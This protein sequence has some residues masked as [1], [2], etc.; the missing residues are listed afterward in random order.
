MK[1]CLVSTH[2]DEVREILPLGLAY[3]A[4]YM[5]DKH[6]FDNTSII[7]VNIE[8]PM[9]G[10]RREKPDV[11]GISTMTLN[12]GAS[13]RLA[14]E[15]KEELDV[16]MLIGGGHISTLHESL[17]KEFDVGVVGEGEETLA[18][19]VDLFE[20][21]GSFP[22]E[23][24]E[25]IEGLVYRKDGALK[26]SKHRELIR[27]LD[28]IPI[29]D[30]KFLSKEYFKPRVVF[31]DGGEVGVE[32]SIFTSRGCPYDCVFCSSAMFWNK[33]RF[34][35]AQRFIDEVR[36][37]NEEY[38]VTHF[39]IWDDLFAVSVKRLGEIAELMKKE[40]LADVARFWG[41][42]RSNIVNEQLCKDL[43][44]MNI[45]SLAFGFE[46][47][48]DR[49]LKYLKGQHMSVEQHKRAAKLCI[50]HGIRVAG[51]LIM[52]TDSETMDEM[53]DTLKFIGELG[54]MG[55][56]DLGVYVMTPFPGTAT[57]Q[58]CKE[59][60]K[61]SDDM[62]WDEL[63]LYGYEK[64]FALD[65]NISRDEFAKLYMEARRQVGLINARKANRWKMLY[66]RMRYF[67]LETMKQ[68]SKRPGRVLRFMRRLLFGKYW[69]SHMDDV[70]VSERVS[71]E[72]DI[73]IQP[74]R[75]RQPHS[76]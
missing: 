2:H 61:V 65:D 16:P 39:L 68:V 53:R 29:P 23:K 59:R 11:V 43:V 75:N 24:L 55:C 12:Y 73:P 18:G 3:L 17:T 38:N 49:M 45:R 50:D 7:D 51:S 62:D 70:P 46:S 30:R 32:T 44:K 5:R 36:Y 57:W 54:E 52:G 35:S 20:R 1:L 63:G 26:A 6:G 69:A 4:T 56:A 71:H 37:L 13:R 40:G 48:N 72:D 66:N 22:A 33:V 9:D 25:G 42:M 27:E 34:N 19:L 21:E 64:P 47:G 76:A 8:P 15:I 67:P 10:L 28:D 31:W 58:V 14:A 74:K 60:G 41:Q